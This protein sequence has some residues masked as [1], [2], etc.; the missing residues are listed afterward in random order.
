MNCS[1]S[2]MGDVSFQGIDAHLRRVDTVTHVPGL[3]CYLC[4]RF[5][6][7]AVPNKALQLTSLSVG[8]RPPSGARS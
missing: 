8:L 3:I 5:V 1:L 7:S 4:T 6:P 2:I